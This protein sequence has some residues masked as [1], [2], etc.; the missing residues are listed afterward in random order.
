MLEVYTESTDDRNERKDKM[1]SDHDREKERERELEGAKNERYIH[2]RYINKNWIC[3]SDRLADQIDH[4]Q[5]N[6]KCMSHRCSITQ[7]QK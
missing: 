5:M 4:N 7:Q 3:V 1:C 2:I 6:L